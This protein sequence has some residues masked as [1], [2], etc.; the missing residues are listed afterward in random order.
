MAPVGAG[1]VAPQKICSICRKVLWFELQPEDLLGTPH[2]S[3]RE[4]LEASAKSCRLCH[5]IL[6]AA[7]ANY[8]DS[9]GR[10]NGKGYWREFVAAKHH[11]GSGVRDVTFVKDLG[12]NMPVNTTGHSKGGAKPILA[13][14][15]NITADGTHI[16][17]DEPS[18]D[19]PT[20]DEDET[21]DLPVWLYGNW[22]SESEPKESNST[23][24]MRLMGVGARFGKTQS[25]FDAFNCKPDWIH[26]RGSQLGIC[27]SDG[28]QTP[29]EH[30]LNRY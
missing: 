1:A 16:D 29:A 10:R 5:M 25:H 11:S 9:R 22:W 12:A 20:I 2:H 21:A 28:E 15:G 19:E 8:R 30:V 26:V 4:A 27:A 7:V 14:T 6:R 18:L 13:H 23:S 3:S 24:Q 17:D